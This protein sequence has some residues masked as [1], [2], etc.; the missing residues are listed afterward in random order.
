MSKVNVAYFLSYSESG[1]NTNVCIYDTKV[2]EGTP[3]GWEE[4]VYYWRKEVGQ[5][6]E[7]GKTNT[8][9]FLH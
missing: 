4:G 6:G 7:T 8:T 9:D 2:Q 3:R 1:Y 5:G